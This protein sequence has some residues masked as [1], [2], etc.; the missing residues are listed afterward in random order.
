MCE[1]APCCGCCGPA[2]VWLPEPD[3]YEF[4]DF[5]DDFGWDGE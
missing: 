4:E 1:D 5:E 3:V 2:D